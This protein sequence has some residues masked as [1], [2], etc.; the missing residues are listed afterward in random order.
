MREAAEAGDVVIV[1]RLAGAILAGRGD[2]VRVFVSAPLAWRIAHVAESLGIGS[3][4]AKDEVNRIDEARRAY[5]REQYRVSWGD[6]RNYDLVLDSSR[7]GID[8]SGDV[9]A[10]AVRAAGG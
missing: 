8:G 2:L 7:F 6:P 5:A 4:A 10:A 1:G 3:A 9:I